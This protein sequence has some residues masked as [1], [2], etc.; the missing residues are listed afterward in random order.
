M[1]VRVI[2]KVRWIIKESPESADCY[3]TLEYL[4]HSREFS[5][6]YSH[7]MNHMKFNDLK[8]DTYHKMKKDGLFSS[9]ANIRRSSRK[10]QE[11]Y[12]ETRGKRWEKRQEAQEDTI[13]SLGYTSP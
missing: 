1:R 12:P 5:Q 9:A 4:I 11:M 10:C 13:R 6:K 3:D 7:K 8:Q 2:D